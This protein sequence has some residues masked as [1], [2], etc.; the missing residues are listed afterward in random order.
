VGHC[1]DANR[2][3]L[4]KASEIPD[5]Q[6]WPWLGR[7]RNLLPFQKQN[8]QPAK[9]EPIMER[10]QNRQYMARLVK[11]SLLSGKSNTIHSGSF[12]SHNPDPGYTGEEAEAERFK[13][14]A[15]FNVDG[16]CLVVTPYDSDREWLPR[17]ADR[18]MDIC[19]VI[20][21]VG[22]DEEPRLRQ[23]RVLANVKG[24]WEIIEGPS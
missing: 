14:V 19:W 17:S 16:P 6:V 8:D 15:V 13:K 18:S 1:I 23:Y 2:K 12:D 7:L 22:N 11:A 24:M 21:R 5:N 4:V 10:Q 9:K 20:E 3:S